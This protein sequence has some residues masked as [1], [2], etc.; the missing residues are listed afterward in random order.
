[1]YFAYVKLF[2]GRESRSES[3]PCG[4]KSGQFL[5]FVIYLVKFTFIF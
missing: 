2:D 5:T 1:M 4:R 3:E